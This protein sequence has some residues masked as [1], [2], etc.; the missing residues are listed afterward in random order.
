MRT[1][2]TGD[3]TLTASIS[4]YGSNL[5]TDLSSVIGPFQVLRDSTVQSRGR[6]SEARGSALLWSVDCPGFDPPGGGF[7]SVLWESGK[8]SV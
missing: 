8:V 4:G 5:C 1:T 2:G 6:T 7:P 3:G